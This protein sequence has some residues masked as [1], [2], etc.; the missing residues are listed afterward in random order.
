MNPLG[1]A[2]KM[3]INILPVS[4]AELEDQVASFTELF[5]EAVNGGASLWACRANDP[6]RGPGLLAVAPARARFGVRLLL[7]PTRRTN[8]SARVGCTSLT[9]RPRAT[10]PSP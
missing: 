6:Q 10:A 7:W 4:S 5:K 3:A 1:A 2:K 9:G 8:S